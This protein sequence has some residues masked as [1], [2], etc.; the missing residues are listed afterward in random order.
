MVVVKERAV[1]LEEGEFETRRLE[2]HLQLAPRSL[3]LLHFYAFTPRTRFQL[4]SA[5]IM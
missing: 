2:K 4:I 3:Q 1:C 5:R